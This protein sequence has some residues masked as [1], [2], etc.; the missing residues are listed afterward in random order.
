MGRDCAWITSV[1]PKLASVLRMVRDCF[2]I[3]TLDSFLLFT[4]RAQLSPDSSSLPTFSGPRLAQEVDPLPNNLGR[5]WREQWSASPSSAAAPLE[6]Q[7]QVLTSGRVRWGRGSFLFT[8]PIVY[9]E[10]GL[11]GFPFSGLVHFTDTLGHAFGALTG[12]PCLGLWWG[13]GARDWRGQQCTPELSCRGEASFP[14]EA[15]QGPTVG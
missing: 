1:L 7:I 15:N 3:I 8:K 6:G 13:V 5:V 14:A 12:R 4:G 9:G 2:L 11:S 10:S